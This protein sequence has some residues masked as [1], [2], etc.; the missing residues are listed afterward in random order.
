MKYTTEMACG[1][2]IYISSL[3]KIGP[4]VQAIL[5]FCVSSL[6]GYSIGFTDGRDL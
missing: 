3:M 6:R 2:T 1:G 5:M 4:G